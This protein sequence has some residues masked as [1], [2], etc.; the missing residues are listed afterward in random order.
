VTDFTRAAELAPSDAY[1]QLW[2]Q[3]AA[4]GTGSAGPLAPG[5]NV[6]LSAW[7]GPIVQTFRGQITR[8]A[9]LSA[10]ADTPDHACEADVFLSAIEL[11]V[12]DRAEAARLLMQAAGSC[13]V[14]NV[15]RYAAVAELKAA[16]LG[17]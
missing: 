2:A 16:G 14:A 7:P 10:A 15:A 17:P 11:A 3:V 4:R 12:A 9:L 1:S 5:A 13:P 8:D 6:D